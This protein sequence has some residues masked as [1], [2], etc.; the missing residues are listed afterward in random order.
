MKINDL[1][2]KFTTQLNLFYLALSFFT[3]LPVPKTMQYSSELLNQSNRYFSLVGLLLGTIVAIY[4]YLFSLALPLAVNILL[5][6]MISILLTGAFHE[7]G[8]T[9]MADGI[10]GAFEPKQ[11]LM[12]MKDSRI[13]TYGSVTLF[14]SLALKF[15][16]LLTLAQDSTLSFITALLLG[17][18]LSR[19]LA[20]SLISAL[21]YVSD[22]NDSK[23]KPLAQSQTNKD[24]LILT[25][26]GAL[27]LFFYSFSISLSIVLTLLFFRIFFVRWLTAKIGGFTGDCLGAAQQISELL[28]YL[29]IVISITNTVS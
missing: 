10:G 9:D 3:R 13:G 4:F 19:A 12:I 25:F 16:L 22:E 2:V 7:D 8:L 15:S 24:I 21:P 23:S 11:R 20:A 26:V 1:K 27:P 17:Y 29:V 14:I 5:I 28:I 6:M 18:S